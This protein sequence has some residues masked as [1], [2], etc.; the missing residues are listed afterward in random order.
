MS[1]MYREFVDIIKHLPDVIQAP[2]YY[3]YSYYYYLYTL[4]T[5]RDSGS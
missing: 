2:C 5:L 1:E 4:L 3:Y